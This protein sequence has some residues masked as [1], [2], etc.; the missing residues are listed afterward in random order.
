MSQLT[1]NDDGRHGEF[2]V[3]EIASEQI[4]L[5]YHREV[6]LLDQVGVSHGPGIERR[7]LVSHGTVL[8]LTGESQLVPLLGLDL[9]AQFDHLNL[10]MKPI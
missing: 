3:E 8:S 7:D 10:Q 1:L 4:G 2:L 6:V 9:P 5:V